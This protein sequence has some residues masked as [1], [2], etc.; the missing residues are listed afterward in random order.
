MNKKNTQK[1]NALWFILIAIILLGL[2]TSMLTRSGGSTN[3][4]GGYE[5]AEIGVSEVLSYA[6]SIDNAVQA[7]KARGCGENEISLWHD[8][9]GDGV[10][11]FGRCQ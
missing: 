4:T 1:G 3:D 9:N 2:L 11:N 10:R 7:L 8:S 6:Q 5:Q